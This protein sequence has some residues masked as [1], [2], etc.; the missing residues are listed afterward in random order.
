VLRRDRR[1]RDAVGQLL[2]RNGLTIDEIQDWWLRRLEL[3]ASCIRTPAVNRASAASKRLKGNVLP[4]GTARLAVHST[5]V[6]QSIYG[7]IQEYAEID[8]PEWL[9]L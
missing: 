5:F 8:R 3:P 1:S 6:V 2:P 9:D 7:A 4:Y